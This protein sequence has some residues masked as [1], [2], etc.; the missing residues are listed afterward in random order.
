MMS[1]ISRSTAWLFPTRKRTD[2]AV[3]HDHKIEAVIRELE[4]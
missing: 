4:A 2:E 1:S 3:V